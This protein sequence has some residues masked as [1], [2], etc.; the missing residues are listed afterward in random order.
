MEPGTQRGLQCV[1]DDADVALAQVR[2]DGVDGAGC[3]RAAVGRFVYL[4][5]PDGNTRPTSRSCGRPKLGPSLRGSGSDWMKI[6]DRRFPVTFGR[7]NLRHLLRYDES[8]PQQTV[9]Q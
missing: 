4:S 9:L 3:G 2:A 7:W 1:I 8:A 6:R 5:D